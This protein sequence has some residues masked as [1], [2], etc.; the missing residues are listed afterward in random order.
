LVG[1]SKQEPGKV[2]LDLKQHRAILEELDLP[3]A[4]KVAEEPREMEPKVQHLTKVELLF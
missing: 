4:G 3:F 1:S 2:Q